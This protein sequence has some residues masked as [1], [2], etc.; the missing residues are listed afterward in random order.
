[1]RRSRLNTSQL[2]MTRFN[3]LSSF[4]GGVPDPVGGT[5]VA[6]VLYVWSVSLRSPTSFSERIVM[7]LTHRRV[8]D[9]WSPTALFDDRH[10]LWSETQTRTHRGPD[11][12]AGH[13][14]SGKSESDHGCD[15]IHVCGVSG[16]G[17]SSGC[18]RSVSVLWTLRGREMNGCSDG[19]YSVNSDGVGAGCGIG[20][21]DDAYDHDL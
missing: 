11:S 17:R 16:F 15:A 13:S 1:M 9:G 10:G 5:V 2:D 6:Y 21:G 12:C 18:Y 14:T 8:R 20:T 19:H 7:E 3:S 4:L